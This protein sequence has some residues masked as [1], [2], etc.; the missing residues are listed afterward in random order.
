MELTASRY[1]RHE[2]LLDA[3][4]EDPRLSSRLCRTVRDALIDY[5][6]KLTEELVLEVIAS[7]IG[8]WDLELLI[9]G[10]HHISIREALAFYKAGVKPHEVEAFLDV[11]RGRS[12]AMMAD[13][14]SR[15]ITGELEAECR[16]LGIDDYEQM[17][18]VSTLAEAA[19]VSVQVFR[20]R[21][22]SA[23]EMLAVLRSR[24][25]APEA[26]FVTAWRTL[27][28]DPDMTIAKVIELMERLYDPETHYNSWYLRYSS[29]MSGIECSLSPGAAAR[30]VQAHPVPLYTSEA[31]RDITWGR[32]F[33]EAVE[34]L[35][36]ASSDVV[37]NA[38]EATETC[39]SEA[40]GVLK[41]LLYVAA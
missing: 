37:V 18:E 2:A 20:I 19:H 33:A 15:G 3:M 1:K 34:S 28:D 24:C 38:I 9:N 36:Q 14:L 27:K 10:K 25:G 11:D 12:P 7:G 21:G 32:S 16:A 29:C 40:L 4:E 39:P 41:S 17:S 30:V 31:L 22:F 23:D 26:K 6:G 35:D 8:G 13:L 5:A